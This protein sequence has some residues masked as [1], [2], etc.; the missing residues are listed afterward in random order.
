[1]IV[2]ALAQRLQWRCLHSYIFIE[3]MIPRFTE[4]VTFSNATWLPHPYAKPFPE[5][6]F[7][8]QVRQSAGATTQEKSLE[9]S[10]VWN[11]ASLA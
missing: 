11:G 5:Q 7:L 2:L 3:K 8:G 10:G 1:M 6:R 9:V 4:K